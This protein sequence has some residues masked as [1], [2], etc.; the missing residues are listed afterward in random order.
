LNDKSTLLSAY[1]NPFNQ[2][3]TL[4]FPSSEYG[5]SAGKIRTIVVYDIYGR[6]ALSTEIPMDEINITLDLSK[7]NS[8]AYFLQTMDDQFSLSKIQR[9]IKL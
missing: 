5:S 6:L 8:G 1:P 2:D 3:I 4:Q 9:I 7:L